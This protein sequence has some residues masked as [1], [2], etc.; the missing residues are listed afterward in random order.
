MAK[1]EENGAALVGQF[2]GPKD[3]SPRVSKPT[4]DTPEKTEEKKEDATP[5]DKAKAYQEGLEAAGIKVEEAR[6]ILD[7]VLFKQGYNE[8]VKVGGKLPVTLRTR[9]YNDSQRVMHFLESEAPTFP[10]HVS[11]LVARYNVA[12]SLGAYGDKVFE[13]PIEEGKVTVQDVEDAFHVRLRFI[14]ALPTPVIDRLITL[15]GDFDRK[16]AAA[17]ADGA[18][19]D[20]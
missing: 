8:V 18:P 11:D 9:V 14:M 17:F 1:M 19:E 2:K 6:E 12:A 20:F 13:F 16:V 10:M 15:T 4:E 7:D 3:N 5:V